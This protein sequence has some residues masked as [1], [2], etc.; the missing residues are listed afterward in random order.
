MS[1]ST[2][3]TEYYTLVWERDGDPPLYLTFG[4]SNYWW[5]ADPPSNP[6]GFTKEQILSIVNQGG[7]EILKAPLKDVY[8][9][10]ITQTLVV[11]KP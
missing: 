5:R 8:I 11:S 1:S 2:R 10:K 4:G 6:W 9:A 3:S 7:R